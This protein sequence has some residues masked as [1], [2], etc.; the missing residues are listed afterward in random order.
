MKIITARRT[1]VPRDGWRALDYAESHYT[2]T[3]VAETLHVGEIA[4]AAALGYLDLRFEGAW[5]QRYPKLVTWLTLFRQALPAF[6]ATGR[7]P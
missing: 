3:P 7:Q 4:L 6:D 5:R 1:N 2:L